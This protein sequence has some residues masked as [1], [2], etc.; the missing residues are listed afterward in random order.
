MLSYFIGCKWEC[1]G[2]ARIMMADNDLMTVLRSNLFELAG[3]LKTRPIMMMTSPGSRAHCL[4]FEELT[5]LWRPWAGPGPGVLV[6]V[7]MDK[8]YSQSSLIGVL[9]RK[10]LDS[11]VISACFQLYFAQ[12][13]LFFLGSFGGILTHGFGLGWRELPRP[14]SVLLQNARERVAQWRSTAALIYPV[15]N[16]H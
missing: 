1:W 12:N 16:T 2:C 8:Y 15:L 9:N 7:F 14:C 11:W 4:I 10:E 3:V 6:T 5:V 13:P